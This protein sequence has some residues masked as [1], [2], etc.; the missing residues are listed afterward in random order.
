MK[1]KRALIL[2]LFLLCIPAL[3]GCGRDRR[4]DRQTFAMGT[5]VNITVYR[6]EEEQYIQPCFSE[7]QRLENALSVNL[8]DSEIS[9]INRS[10]TGKVS[11]DTKEILIRALDFAQK[12]E[13]V[14]DPCILPLKRLWDIENHTEGQPL[15]TKEEVR[16]TLLHTGYSNIHLQGDSVTLSDGGIDLGGIAKGYAADACAEILEKNGVEKA[17]VNIGGNVRVIGSWNATIGVK[18]PR[19]EDGALVMSLPVNEAS[20]V[21]SGDYE[22]YFIQDGV[23]YH[24]I[25]D[26]KTG[27]PASSGVLSVTVL[28]P[29]GTTA[30]A[31]STILF[32]MGPEKGQEFLQEWDYD[33][34]A[35][36]IMEDQTI[37]LTEG[38]RELVTIESEEYHIR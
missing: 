13:G 6:N 15:P 38:M 34:Q 8:G 23:R 30:D 11:E 17:I 25:F 21:T 9:Q 14:F 37:V 29:D 12:S 10:H 5:F 3:G 36:W 4:I 35:A 20:L 16:E 28:C 32:V 18:D 19:G 2:L 22:R 33:A 1:G 27:Y 7:V 24:H 26:T 31:L